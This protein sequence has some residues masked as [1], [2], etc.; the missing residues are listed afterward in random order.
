MKG[1]NKIM[2]CKLIIPKTHGVILKEK[3]SLN[4][5]NLIRVC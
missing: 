4:D 1:D 3:V 5:I 2:T